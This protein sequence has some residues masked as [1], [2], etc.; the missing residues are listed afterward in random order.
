MKAK[1]AKRRSRRASLDEQAKSSSS[2]NDLKF[3][4]INLNRQEI[5]RLEVNSAIRLFLIHKDP[6]S[7]H[8]LA[9]AAT[10]IMTVLSNGNLEV[11]LNGLRDQLQKSVL[12]YDDQKEVFDNL[13]H[14]YNF[15]KHSSSDPDVTNRFSVDYIG[16]TVYMAIHSYKVLFGGVSSE[17]K[18]FYGIFQVW[19]SEFWKDTPNYP[20]I[21]ALSEPYSLGGASLEKFCEVGQRL[22]VEAEKQQLA[23]LG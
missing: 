19:K 18:V 6:I 11:G 20:S 9:C 14:P 21:V 13:L 15:L 2:Q 3:E 17:M 23:S 7:A 1:L 4:Y 22:L 16:I 5:C 10:E 8:L 12:P